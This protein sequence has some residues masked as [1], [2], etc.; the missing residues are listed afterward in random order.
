MGVGCQWSVIVAQQRTTHSQQQS[1]QRIPLP[2]E[3]QDFGS[4][5]DELVKLVVA[6]DLVLGDRIVHYVIDS[7]AGEAEDA[8]E[9]LLA[10]D[11]RDLW[12]RRRQR[13]GERQPESAQGTHDGKL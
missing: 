9:R 12:L 6:E 5:L 10:Q 4:T 3:I 7:A 11:V 13:L 1:T 8:I 2:L